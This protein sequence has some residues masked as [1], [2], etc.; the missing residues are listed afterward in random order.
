MLFLVKL[1]INIQNSALKGEKMY[2][3]LL[4]CTGNTCRSPMLETLIKDKLKK[5]GK[6]AE[7][8]SAGLS[9]NENDK[10]NPKSRQALKDF[11][12]VIRHKP[13]LLT[14]KA[15]EKADTVITMTDEQKEYLKMDKCFYKVYSLR[16]TVGFNA[17]D[18]YG[19][20]LEVYKE[21]AKLLDYA[22]ETIVQ[23]LI[24]AGKV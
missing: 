2:R 7:V 4:V 24:K 3:I 19:G 8:K 22:A 17:S 21:C 13:T 1:Y 14:S 16:E 12:L 10:V 5:L 23:N 15:L 6:T 9:V 20:S 11:G 18:P